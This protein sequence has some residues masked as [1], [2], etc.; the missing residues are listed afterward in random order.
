MTYNIQ[1]K[2]YL[3]IEDQEEDYQSFRNELLK[4]GIAQDQIERWKGIPDKCET[5]YDLIFISID[6]VQAGQNNIIQ[7]LKS[8]FP[9]TAIIALGPSDNYTTAVHAIQ[10]GIQD[11]LIKEQINPIQLF[12]AIQG[13]FQQK[14]LRLELKQKNEE[15]ESLFQNNPRPL[16]TFDL[17]SLEIIKSN[18]AATKEYGFTEEEFKSFSLKSIQPKE[19][20]D[21]LKET[22][23]KYRDTDESGT[24]ITRH[25]RK[26]GETID[27]ELSFHALD[28]HS[29]TAIASLNNI[30]EKVHTKKAL[31]KC[32]QRFTHLSRATSDIIYDWNLN[33]NKIS[34]GE[35]KTSGF[36]H[37]GIE[38]SNIQKW[39]GLIHPEDQAAFISHWDKALSIKSHEKKFENYYRIQNAE[40]KYAHVK[41]K[42]IILINEENNPYRI[43]GAM[44]DISDLIQAED[45]IKESEKKYSLLFNKSPIPKWYC[46]SDSLQILDVN[47]TAIDRYGYSKKDFRKLRLYDL[48]SNDDAKELRTK[49]SALIEEEGSLNLG[50]WKQIKQDGEEILVE[51]V[52]HYL[53]LENEGK[54]LFACIDITE[55]ALQKEKLEYANKRFEYVLEATYDAIWDWDIENNQLYWG[56][57]FSKI[58]G[59][60]DGAADINFNDWKQYIHPEDR[61]CVLEDLFKTLQ[62]DAQEWNYKYRFQRG[63]GKYAYVEDKCLVLRNEKGEAYRAIG[64]MQDITERTQKEQQLELMESVVK[65][66]ND[67]ILITEGS[68]IDEPGPRII[69]ANDAFFKNTAYKK[70]EVIGRSPRFLQGPKTDRKALDKVRQAIEQNESCK[71]EVINYTKFGDEF[72]VEFSIEPVK[73]NDKTHFISI[74][75]DVT[76]RKLRENKNELFR[77]INLEISKPSDLKGRYDIVLKALADYCDFELAEG[78]VTNIDNTEINRI[79]TYSS[80]SSLSRFFEEGTHF[81]KAKIGEG[82][83]GKLWESRELLLWN[84]IDDHNLFIR[85]EE[86]KRLGLKSAIGIPLF[87]LDKLIGVIMF[88][89]RKKRE[90]L[91]DINE[92]LKEVSHQFGAEFLRMKSEEQLNTFFQLSPDIFSIIDK[93]GQIKKVN[94]AFTQLLGYTQ[95]EAERMDIFSIV[96]P[97]DIEQAKTIFESIFNGDQQDYI[98]SRVQ[99]KAGKTISISLSFNYDKDEE[100]IYAVAK[101]ITEQKRLEKLLHK[102]NELAKIGSWEYD[103]IEGNTY[104]SDTTREIYEVPGDFEPKLEEV[105]NYYDKEGQKKITQL[106]NQCINGERNRWEAEV[107]LITATENEKWVHVEGT[108]EWKNGKC[109]RIYGSIQDIH[110]RKVAEIKL[111]E[112]NLRYQLATEATE[113]GIWDWDIVNNEVVLDDKIY[114]LYGIS[115]EDFEG[116]YEELLELIHPDDVERFKGKVKAALQDDT[117][118]LMTYRVIHPDKSIHHLKA[119]SEIIKDTDGKPYRL[120]GINYDIT[121]EIKQQEE[122]AKA[123]KEREDILESITDG[124]FAVDHDWNVTYWNAAAEEIVSLSRNEIIDKN[125]WNVFDEVLEDSFHQALLESME[126]KKMLNF[127]HYYS[128]ADLWLQVSTYPRKYG[129]A[130]FFKNITEQ[131][132]QEQQIIKMRNLQHHV[133]NST[134]DLIWSID[135]DYRLVLANEA[136][137]NKM[138]I[139]SGVEYAIGKKV[140]SQTNKEWDLED[141]RKTKWSKIYDRALSGERI[142]HMLSIPIENQIRNFQI[143]IHPIY[144]KGNQDKDSIIGLACFSRDVTERLEY[145]D[146]IEDQNKRLKDI[147]WMQSHIVRAPVTRIMGLAK[148]ILEDEEDIEKINELLP[149]ILESA[150]ELDN[151]IHQINEKAKAIEITKNPDK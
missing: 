132:K 24:Y 84:D 85:K 86:A 98:E 100:L 57:N 11:Y 42:S 25:Q 131:K 62:G 27:V 41:D 71:V 141:E 104:W 150:E 139:A 7:T 56:K 137:L 37:M 6:L 99:S 53:N 60:Q 96:E 118:L 66:S 129:L 32:N 40:G 120:V 91:E 51:M 46:E 108:S 73:Y 126:E 136:Y 1:N 69:F 3:I 33:T 39:I 121:E 22:I 119:H 43:I 74:Q 78:W 123:H 114:E 144:Q 103:L 101:D 10:E 92:I 117:K 70:E 106:F 44:E 45:K 88:F 102:S 48:M 13:A 26:N 18:K 76:K 81:S 134:T 12:K 151:I 30:T 148:L 147:A 50:E 16:I 55:N 58:F 34:W 67:A 116:A 133:I 19:D 47:E 65:N 15:I 28:D 140:A 54:I 142:T 138:K 113:L 14:G 122:L 130:V 64:A 107:K 35:T 4:T 105:I 112:T 135:K 75:R 128:E 97:K 21:L 87:Y 111:Y 149:H 23:A 61:E 2:E 38:K 83:P 79:T 5:Y 125:F 93:N 89:T 8:Q 36:E 110:E 143:S 52:A 145:I 94:Q 59:H 63:N 115:E 49:I 109:T 124:F 127:D 29:N 9:Q 20:Y 80:D 82:L 90:G 72:W 146:A 95:D 31:S 68:P 17:D 77:K